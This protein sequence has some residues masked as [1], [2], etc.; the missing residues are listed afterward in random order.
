MDYNFF[1]G[2]KK[3]V[4]QLAFNEEYTGPGWIDF[5]QMKWLGRSCGATFFYDTDKKAP[6]NPLGIAV[7]PGVQWTE[8]VTDKRVI[9]HINT[10]NGPITVVHA[11]AYKK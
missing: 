11:I 10:R 7:Y 1:F 3:T 4:K 8:E 2:P 6:D 5:V 9:N